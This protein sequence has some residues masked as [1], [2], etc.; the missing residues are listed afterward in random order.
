M[1]VEKAHLKIPVIDGKNILKRLERYCRVCYKSEDKF[2]S[3]EYGCGLLKTI[4]AKNHESVLE[5]EKLS[6]LFV[7]DRGISH[8]LIRHR[9]ASYSQESTRYCNYSKEKFG[10]EITV[11]KPVFFK[12]NKQT[13]WEKTMSYIENSYFNLLDEGAKPEE[14]RSILPNSLK[15]EIVVTMNYRS[16]RNFFKLRC[17]TAAHPQIKEVAIPFLRHLQKEL[18]VLFM[19]ITYDTSFSENNYAYI[20]TTD[21]F[22]QEIE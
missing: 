16:L 12:E 2:L 10:R 7:I 6:I 14:A 15:T 3:E 5:H 17:Q 20:V 18:P 4:I 19:D 22:F 1:R 13:I 9:M 11:I 21:E 8:E